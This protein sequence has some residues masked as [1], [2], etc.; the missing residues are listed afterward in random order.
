MDRDREV[1]KLRDAL[2]WFS[3]MLDGRENQP[4]HERTSI[5]YGELWKARDALKCTRS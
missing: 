3:N 5:T 4:L 2:A 1:A